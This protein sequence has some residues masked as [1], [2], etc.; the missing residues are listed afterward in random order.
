MLW[1]KWVQA[2]FMQCSPYTCSWNTETCWKSSHAGSRATLYHVKNVLL[3]LHVLFTCPF[4][5]NMSTGKRTAFPQCIEHLGKHSR[6]PEFCAQETVGGILRQQQWHYHR[7]S[8]KHTAY[9]HIRH[10]WRCAAFFTTLLQCHHQQS[11]QP[12]DA[13]HRFTCFRQWRSRAGGK[14]NTGRP[15]Q[16][17]TV[18]SQIGN[19]SE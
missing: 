19:R 16:T 9:Q 4:R 13:S 5:W 18:Y 8:R 1:V 11:Q 7:R 3:F 2:V 14:D 12:T 10:L 15:S 6:D 17:T